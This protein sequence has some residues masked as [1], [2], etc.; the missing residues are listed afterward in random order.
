MKTRKLFCTLLVLAICA[1]FAQVTFAQGN[2]RPANVQVINTGAY[3]QVINTGAYVEPINTRTPVTMING[4]PYNNLRCMSTDCYRNDSY[5]RYYI[6]TYNDLYYMPNGGNS[7]QHRASNVSA[8]GFS[9]GRVAFQY[10]QTG[11]KTGVKD[12]GTW[13]TIAGAGLAVWEMIR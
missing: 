7:W 13:L 8:L 5:G 3:V 11:R 1:V 6:D 10:M 4:I 9:N 12:P 2:W